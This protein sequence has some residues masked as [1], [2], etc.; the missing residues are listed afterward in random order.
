MNILHTFSKDYLDDILVR[1][2]YHSAGIEG[3]TISLPATVSIIVNGTLPMSGK[4]TVREF[5]EIENHKHA[6][7]NIL[8][9][10]INEETL[11][12]DIIKEIHADLTDRLQYNRGQFK[13]NE[14][15]ILGA[16]FQTASPAETPLLMAQL[17]DNLIY[18]LERSE[19]DDEKL[20]AI[21]DT[22][23]QFE[24]I[25]PFSDGNGRTGRMVL[26]YSLLQQGFPP[27][28]IEKETKAEYIEFL[29]N[30]DVDGFFRFAKA[31]LEKEQ[32]RMQG[33]QNMEQEKIKFPKA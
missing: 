7:D 16:E 4:A 20:I 9:H 3:N 18:R 15:M 19:S 33:F 1:L 21:L 29:G 22:H 25:H 31:L 6:F 24:R 23:I 17:V 5:Y 11:T 28:I 26:N 10:L 12:I 8:T 32:R 30:Q 2:A 27:L 13:K 14:N